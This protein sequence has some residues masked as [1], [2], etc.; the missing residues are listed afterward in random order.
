MQVT[1]EHG[2]LKQELVAECEIRLVIREMCHGVSGKEAGNPDA[3]AGSEGRRIGRRT[4]N[5]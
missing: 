3:L 2:L 1:R 5:G 4:V